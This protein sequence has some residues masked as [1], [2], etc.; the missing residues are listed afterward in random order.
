[1]PQLDPTHPKPPLLVLTPSSQN[2]ARGGHRLLQRSPRSRRKLVAGAAVAAVVSVVMLVTV[3]AVCLARLQRPLSQAAKRRRLSHTEDDSNELSSILDQCVDLQDEHGFHLPAYELI[4]EREATQ[5]L[6]AMLHASASAFEGSRAL[7]SPQSL[8]LEGPL[9]RYGPPQRP[10]ITPQQLPHTEVWGGLSGAAIGPVG[11]PTAVKEGSFAGEEDAEGD[12]VS[13][14]HAHSSAPYDIAEALTAAMRATIDDDDD[15]AAAHGGDASAPQLVGWTSATPDNASA[16]AL[17]PDAWLAD[18]PTLEVPPVVQQSTKATESS[19]AAADDKRAGPV[20]RRRRRRVKQVDEIQQLEAAFAAAPGVVAPATSVQIKRSGGS[21]N[22]GCMEDQDLALHPFVRLPAVNPE[23]LSRCFRPE[24][25]LTVKLNLLSPMDS[26][27]EM[28]KLF[29]KPS[30][31]VKEVERLLFEAE[32]LANYAKDKLAFRINRRKPSYIFRR[33]SSLFMVFDY[34]MCAIE[35]L[36]DKMLASS[37]WNEFTSKF[38]TEFTLTD[39]WHMAQTRRASRLVNRI[40]AAL[41][42]YKQG[43]R[44]PFEEVIALK[45]I[46]LTEHCTGSQLMHPLWKLW[47]QDDEE[48][49]RSQGCLNKR[50]CDH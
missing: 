3:F 30:L 27:L 14:S 11:G 6:V 24:Y 40:S 45:R 46:V 1:M 21:D 37:W 23:E 43:H 49:L 29:A 33:L 41:S 31:T 36:G 35:T 47:L 16:A 28:R 20:R 26:F 4:E 42:I 10:Y 18:L 8:E 34:L 19:L 48:F 15:A 9:A 25:A 5:K 12:L 7:V 2:T 39:D 44:P 50:P 32:N 22:Q 38:E 13:A 17:S